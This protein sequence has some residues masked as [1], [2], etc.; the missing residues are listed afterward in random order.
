VPKLT[1]KVSRA[2]LIALARYLERLCDKDTPYLPQRPGA[3]PWPQLFM[4]YL[5]SSLRKMGK[6]FPRTKR[7]RESRVSSKAAQT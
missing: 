6:D 1:V 2:G 3:E 7:A 4:R 5:A